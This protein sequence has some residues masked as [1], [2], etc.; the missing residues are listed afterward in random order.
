MT[1]AS[2]FLSSRTRRKSVTVFGGLA[3]SLD[4]SPRAFERT[5]ESTSHRYARD[6]FLPAA[7]A[8]A[9]TMPRP[10]SPITA[11]LSLS[12]GDPSSANNGCAPRVAARAPSPTTDALFRKSRRSS[13][14]FGVMKYSGLQRPNLDIAEENFVDVI[15]KH[16]MP[17]ALLREVGDAVVF[18]FGEQR[19]HLRRAELELHH[20]GSVE[21]VLAVIAA[22]DDPRAVPFAYRRELFVGARCDQ[23][24]KRSGAVGRHLVVFVKTVVQHLVLEAERRVVGRVR[25][26]DLFGDVVFDA[27]VSGA[28]DLP[29]P[30]KVKIAERIRRH[31]VA[32]GSRLT[33][34]EARH[35]AISELPDGAVFD[36]PM[37]AGY[38]V[39]AEPAPAVEGRAIEQQAP[40]CALLVSGQSI[41]C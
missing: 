24:V 12:A 4:T 34:R 16:D 32:A 39:V 35:I 1:S 33:I 3:C 8:W 37:G 14:S 10:L 9:C 20:L 15:L 23:I 2:T 38:C 18:A 11:T 28:T 31:Q 22:K 19:I 41:C 25:H 7:K 21:P 5:F 26:R 17:G 27:A 29:F 6:V 40:S 36:F 13:G 30:R